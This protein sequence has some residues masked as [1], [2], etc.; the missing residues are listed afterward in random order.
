MPTDSAQQQ[1]GITEDRTHRRAEFLRDGHHDFGIFGRDG[2]G[3]LRGRSAWRA[4]DLVFEQGELLLRL[5]EL[6]FE[7]LALVGQVVDHAAQRAD[8]VLAELFQALAVTF[9]TGHQL[10]ALRLEGGVFG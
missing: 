2:L 8:A 9:G 4:A 1:V 10:I 3:R 7:R 5:R 6:I